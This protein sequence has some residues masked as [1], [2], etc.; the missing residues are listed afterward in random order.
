MTVNELIEQLKNLPKNWSTAVFLRSL[1]PRYSHSD[2]NDNIRLRLNK[3]IE[4]TD[5]EEFVD[6][7]YKL[8]L[9]LPEGEDD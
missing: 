5:S 2:M 3:A 9:F 8:G 1:T 6:I 7:A 4:T